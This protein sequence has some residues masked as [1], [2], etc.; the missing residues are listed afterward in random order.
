VTKAPKARLRYFKVEMTALLIM[1]KRLQAPTYSPA[2][3]WT[4]IFR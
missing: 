4:L 2:A 1:T 3:F